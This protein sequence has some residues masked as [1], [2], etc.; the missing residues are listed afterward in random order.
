MFW[1]EVLRRV[2]RD[3]GGNA[4]ELLSGAAGHVA[5][6]QTPPPRRRVSLPRSW[7]AWVALV[8]GAV[9]ASVYIIWPGE[10][11]RFLGL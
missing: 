8:I 1:D 9:V 3:H 7:V 5:V 2:R 11:S 10:V 6:P 4:L